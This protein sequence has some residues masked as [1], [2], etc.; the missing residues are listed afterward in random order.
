VAFGLSRTLQS[1]GVPPAAAYQV[2]IAASIL[3]TALLWV[4]F[5][6]RQPGPPRVDPPALPVSPATAGSVTGSV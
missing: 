6:R 5:R 1:A 2:M 3:D 4:F